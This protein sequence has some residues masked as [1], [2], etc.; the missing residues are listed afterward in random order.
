M[1]QE[2]IVSVRGILFTSTMTRTLH[3]FSPSFSPIVDRD[4]KGALTLYGTVLTGVLVVRIA[5]CTP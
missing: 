1:L 4:P 3:E 2:I 5:T